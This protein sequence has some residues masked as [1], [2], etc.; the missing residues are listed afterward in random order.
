M[1]YKIIFISISLALCFGCAEKPGFTINGEVA[2]YEGPIYL[3]YNNTFDSTQ[4]VDG[5]FI[6]TGS[7]DHVI[8]AAL[9]LNKELPGTNSLYFGNEIVSVNASKQGEMLF[10]DDFEGPTS[11]LITQVVEE[12]TVIYEDAQLVRSNALFPYTDSIIDVHP[13]NEFILEISSEI[14]TS[15]FLTVAQCTA[16][17]NK[18]DTTVMNASDLK[19]MRKTIARMEVLNVGDEFPEFNLTDQEGNNLTNEIF[20]GKYLLVDFWATWCMPCL[21]SFQKLEKIYPKHKDKLEVLS[22]S[23]D[24]SEERMNKYMD[25]NPFPWKNSYVKDEF[26]NPFVQQLGVVFLPFTYLINPEGKIEAINIT[27]DQLNTF[28]E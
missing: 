25:T 15:G 18:M 28:I 5:Q 27:V 11:D 6:F 7:V 23:L 20:T 16:L 21:E 22:V 17:M 4:V 19:A 10:I 13:R 3:R 24:L 14:V 26:D 8:E 1:Q 9:V 2:D 12:M